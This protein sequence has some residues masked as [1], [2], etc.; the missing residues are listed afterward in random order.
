MALILYRPIFWA[1][2]VLLSLLLFWL[3]RRLRLRWL[4]AWIIRVFSCRYE[5]FFTE[6]AKEAKFALQHDRDVPDVDKFSILFS[7]IYNWRH[8]KRKRGYIR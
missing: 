2:Y 1:L 8:L 5:F 4:P 6:L 7:S 3:A